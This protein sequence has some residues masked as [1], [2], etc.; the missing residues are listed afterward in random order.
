MPG[1]DHELTICTVVYRDEPFVEAHQRLAALLNPDE[2]LQWVV[3]ANKPAPPYAPPEIPGC[4]IRIIDG[5]DPPG[6]PE[7]GKRHRSWHHAAGLALAT[8][9]LR[10]RFVLLLDSDC[11]IV[12]PRWVSEIPAYMRAN[13]LAFFGVPYH[14]RLPIKMR[15]V[16]CAVGLFVDTEQVELASLDWVPRA[17][18]PLKL[19]AAETLLRR[20]VTLVGEKDRL[21]IGSSEDTGISV[22]RRARTGALRHDAATPVLLRHQLLPLVTSPRSLALD[23]LL[24]ESLSYVPKRRGAWAEAGFAPE[25]TDFEEFVWKQEPFAFHLRPTVKGADRS[26]VDLGSLLGRFASPHQHLDAPAGTT[27][28]GGTG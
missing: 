19:S 22:Y 10:S 23:R 16:P 1:A 24:P 14:P 21:T 7:G 25:L 26:A 12:R 3:V 9:H 15:G 17:S 27:E 6:D 8:P 18:T 5:A 4:E 13:R 2:T 11:F 20:I 28:V